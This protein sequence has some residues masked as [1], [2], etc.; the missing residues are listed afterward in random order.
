[1][2]LATSRTTMRPS[3]IEALLDRVVAFVNSQS[4][5]NGDKLIRAFDDFCDHVPQQD[6]NAMDQELL[7]AIAVLVTRLRRNRGVPLH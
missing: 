6:A 2:P 5:R 1:M 7:E 3:H 4:G